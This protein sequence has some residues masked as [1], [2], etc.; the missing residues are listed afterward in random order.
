MLTLMTTYRQSLVPNH[1]VKG[2]QAYSFNY[3]CSYTGCN[4][5][6]WNIQ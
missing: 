5:Q 3:V 6:D 4:I 1:P 2:N